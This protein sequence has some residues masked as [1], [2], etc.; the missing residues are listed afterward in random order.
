MKSS[1]DF[2]AIITL[3]S[4][5]RLQLSFIRT[6]ALGL[7]VV[8]FQ[9]MRLAGSAEHQMQYQTAVNSRLP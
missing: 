4:E 7:R 6:F 2:I 5:G 9:F 3:K 8:E 1:T